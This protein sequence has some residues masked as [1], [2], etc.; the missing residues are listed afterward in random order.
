MSFAVWITG[1]PGSGKSTIAKEL[2]KHLE[3]VEYLRLD[4]IRKKFVKAPKFTDEERDF[5]YRAFA[6]EGIKALKRNRHVV[7]DAAAHKLKWRDFA[8][9]RIEEF[10]EVYVKCPVD[11]CIK[12]EGKRKSKHVIADLYKKSL[13]RKKSGKVFKGLGQVVGVDVPYEESKNTDI[14]IYSD[15]VSSEEGADLILNELKRRKWIK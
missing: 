7:Y 10:I 11:I 5:V 13:E 14:V 4:E 8:R 6:E 2:I 15:K 3:N 12:R 1:L 9:G